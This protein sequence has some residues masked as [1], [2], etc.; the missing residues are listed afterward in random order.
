MR[1]SLHSLQASSQIVIE[2]LGRFG[3]PISHSVDSDVHN[4]F[5][6]LTCHTAL[7]PLTSIA[8][9]VLDSITSYP[10]PEW[11]IALDE[12]ECLIFRESRNANISVSSRKITVMLSG[13][14]LQHNV[15]HI[16]K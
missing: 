5:T 11:V 12:F 7:L 15:V 6:S 14:C 13:N 1:T 10:R 4:D 8:F 16:Q 9:R 3:S 2:S